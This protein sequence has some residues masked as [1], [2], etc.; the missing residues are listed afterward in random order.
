MV[1][2]GVVIVALLVL[3]AIPAWKIFYRAPSCFD[4]A[5]NGSET[6]IDCGGS[7]VKLCQSAFAAPVVDWTRFEEVAPGLYNLAAY[8]ENLNIDAEAVDVPYRVQ[9]YDNRGIIITEYYG[10]LTLPPHRNTLAFQGAVSV[11]QRVP[12]KA[13]FEFVA[14][15]DWSKKSDPL[16]KLVISDKRYEENADG[17]VLSVKLK[18]S[19]VEP[20]GRISVYT[21]LYDAGGNALGF[22][23]TIIDGIGAGETAMAPFT[24]PKGHDGAV[25]SIEV[26]PV[27]E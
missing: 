19:G 27:S 21:V 12:A 23:K 14:N 8:I 20:I 1:F 4:G 7:C 15:P 5:Q 6:G 3:V 22:S 11:K 10:R 13:L 24:W 25:V 9:L 16:S 17:S 26:L 18:N 2:G